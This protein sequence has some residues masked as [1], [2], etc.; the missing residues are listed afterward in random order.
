MYITVI[1]FSIV[2]FVIFYIFKGPNGNEKIDQPLFFNIDE[3]VNKTL[4]VTLS[5]TEKQII[6]NKIRYCIDKDVILSDS[7]LDYIINQRIKNVQ[8]N[9][10]TK[11]EFV[12]RLLKNDFEKIHDISFD[13]F[14]KICKD[15][16][17]NNPQ[18]LI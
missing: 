16:H 1:L 17:K 10:E 4:V 15:I 3:W 11:R 13:E 8:Q 5:P 18:D 6:E 7:L 14:M 9:N 2:A 12:I